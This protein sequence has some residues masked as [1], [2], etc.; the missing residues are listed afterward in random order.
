MIREI[1][2]DNSSTTKP[3]DEVVQYIYEVSKDFYGNPSSMH[4][5]GI[6]AENLVK[7]A[8]VQLADALK[9]D[10]KEICFTSGGTESNN[11]AII[12]FLKANPRAGKH[13]ITS[14]IE[15]PSISEVYKQ[16]ACV[17]YIVDYIPV[18]SQGIIK[19]DALRAALESET[20]LIS[21]IHTNNETGSIQPIE[22]INKIRKAICPAAVLH[23]DA[24][25]AFGKTRIYPASCNVDLLS[26]SSH[27]IHGP[28]G[29]GALYIRKGIKI[30]PILLGGGQEKSLRSGTENVPGICGFGLATEKTF[31]DI[32]ESYTQVSALKEHFLLNI[33]KC[34][35]DAMINSPEQASP[36]II[37][38][39]FP[40][41][42]SEVLLHHLEQTNIFVSTGSACSSLKNKHSHVLKAM[43][44]SSKYIDGAIRFS[45]SS[46]NT[47][48]DMDETINAL[49]EI[50]PV[51]SIKRG[52]KL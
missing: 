20:A 16:L 35:E 4:T 26:I 21:F 28:K 32:N 47:I 14:E 15:H 33:K 42:K 19:L 12:G 9:V 36:Y 3:Y 7:H 48:S 39:S 29:M 8:R 45:L 30:K 37:N 6:E 44:V 27:K 52:G 11:L 46:S 2:L 50:I 24:V 22:E 5:K 18:D 13:I 38:V 43:G 10:A 49:K 1:Y 51:I 34:F 25:Q 17:G 23:I 31:A 41:L 40:N